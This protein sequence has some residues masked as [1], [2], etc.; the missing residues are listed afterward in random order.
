MIIV[1]HLL[2]EH[3]RHFYG[4]IVLLEHKRHYGIIVGE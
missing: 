2:L 4:I 3:K 1:A